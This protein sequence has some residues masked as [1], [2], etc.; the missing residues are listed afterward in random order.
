MGNKRLESA[1]FGSFDIAFDADI[2]P[3]NQ[4]PAVILSQNKMIKL[5]LFCVHL[6]PFGKPI[7]ASKRRKEIDRLFD[8]CLQQKVSENLIICGDMNMRFHEEM[9]VI[10]EYNGN[11]SS[12]WSIVPDKLKN[13]CMF[14]WYYNYFE[15]GA[16]ACTRFDK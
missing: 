3:N 4:F 6:H 10:N 7:D 8:L 5:C 15:V 12:V 2:D 11:L 9:A 16:E 1:Q 13:N 14:S